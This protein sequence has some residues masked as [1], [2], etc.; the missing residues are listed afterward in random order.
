M[1]MMMNQSIFYTPEIIL[2]MQII[3]AILIIYIDTVFISNKNL[4]LKSDLEIYGDKP[5]PN[6]PF[7]ILLLCLHIFSY[8]LNLFKKR[9]IRLYGE[10]DINGVYMSKRE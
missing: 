7:V 1:D 9:E 4:R 2:E 10:P 3:S 8:L 5:N 6:E